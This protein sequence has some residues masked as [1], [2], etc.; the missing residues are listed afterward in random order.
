MSRTTQDYDEGGL[1]VHLLIPVNANGQGPVSDEETVGYV[2][3][4]G[5]PN[6]DKWLDDKWL[7]A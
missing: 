1:P 5:T 2:C 6:C 3:W 7:D 4:C